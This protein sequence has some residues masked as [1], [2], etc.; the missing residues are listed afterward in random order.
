MKRLWLILKYIGQI[1]TLVARVARLEAELVIDAEQEKMARIV[2]HD[3]RP[4]IKQ[5]DRIEG[6]LD[7][8]LAR[9]RKN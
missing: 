8:F 3:K 1:D 6:A 2:L 4:N 5:M 9:L 7:T